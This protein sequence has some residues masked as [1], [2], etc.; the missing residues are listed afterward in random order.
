MHVYHHTCLS[1]A[2]QY[3]ISLKFVTS[4]C[5][6]LEQLLECTRNNADGENVEIL[7]CF[8]EYLSFH[9][10]QFNHETFENVVNSLEQKLM[11]NVTYEIK[12]RLNVTCNMNDVN[13]NNKK[14][15]HYKSLENKKTLGRPFHLKFP[16]LVQMVM[17]T[18]KDVIPQ[19]WF[20]ILWLVLSQP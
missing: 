12:P 10:P 16:S 11:S 1:N 3:G 18:T 15:N 6:G 19:V 17:Q 20:T 2:H 4:L 8:N 5:Q 9:L 7:I 13:V 14:R